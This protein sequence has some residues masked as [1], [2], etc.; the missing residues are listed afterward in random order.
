VK[1]TPTKRPDGARSLVDA[2]PR[3][4]DARVAFALWAVAFYA[5]GMAYVY[6]AL[7]SPA[8]AVAAVVVALGCLFPLLVP[9]GRST[10]SG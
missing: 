3:A 2:I 9:P 8:M 6:D 7:S 1:G 10:R 4:T 5:I